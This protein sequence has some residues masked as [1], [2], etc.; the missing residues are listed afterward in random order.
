M[1]VN[2]KIHL[3]GDYTFNQSILLKQLINYE[4]YILLSKCSIFNLLITSEMFGEN[5]SHSVILTIDPTK[6]LIL[7][8]QYSYWN[9]T[10]KAH[11]F[12]SICFIRMT[13]LFNLG[14]RFSSDNGPWSFLQKFDLSFAIFHT[15]RSYHIATGV[16]G[17]QSFLL[18]MFLTLMCVIYGWFLFFFIILFSYS[19]HCD[20]FKKTVK[21]CCKCT[22]LLFPSL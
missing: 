3:W 10:D 6:N 14:L 17:I 12:Y 22:L 2:T 1:A 13:F 19:D 8:P 9:W 20:D 18:F 21:C 11:L 7:T 16:L 15:T 5:G 4:T